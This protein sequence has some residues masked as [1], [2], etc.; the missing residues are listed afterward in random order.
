MSYHLT[1]KL[2][3]CPFPNLTAIGVPSEQ[4]ALWCCV[5]GERS[6]L[7]SDIGQIASQHPD[8]SFAS[9]DLYDAIQANNF[10]EW[11]LYLQ[12]ISYGDQLDYDFDPLDPTKVPVLPR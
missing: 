9:Q 2:W 8:G 11:Y 1:V 6:L 5:V 12:T 3:Q 4:F 10:P 7:D